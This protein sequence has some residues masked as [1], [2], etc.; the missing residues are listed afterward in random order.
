MLGFLKIK[1][2]MLFKFKLILLVFL[3]FP[4]NVFAEFQ[5]EIKLIDAGKCEE[6]HP[7]FWAPFILVGG[8]S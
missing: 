2:Y 4:L 8:S 6:A 3:I 1:T 7:I 5:K